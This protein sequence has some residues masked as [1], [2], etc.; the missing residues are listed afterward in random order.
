MAKGRA[1]KIFSIGILTIAC[2]CPVFGVKVHV[3]AASLNETVNHGDDTVKENEVSLSHESQNKSDEPFT[4]GHPHGIHGKPTKFDMDETG[5]YQIESTKID[6]VT[7]NPIE[8]NARTT[9]RSPLNSTRCDG[10]RSVSCIRRNF[11]NFLDRLSKID[12][13][14]VTESVQIV[15]KPEVNITCNGLKDGCIDTDT[16]LLNKVHRYA[17]QHVMKIHLKGANDLSLPRK[18][19]TFFGCEFLQS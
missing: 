2:L 16:N 3:E 10:L 8:L 19:R 4:D 1:A 14:N 6:K 17:R 18:A 13:Y 7:I 9:P 15:R 5:D 11:I 12:T